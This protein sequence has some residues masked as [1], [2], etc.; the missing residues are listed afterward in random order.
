MCYRL[1]IKK[2]NG[3]QIDAEMSLSIQVKK[4]SEFWEVQMG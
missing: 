1:N 4:N 2:Y 3:F